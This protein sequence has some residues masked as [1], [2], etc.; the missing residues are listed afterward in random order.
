MEKQLQDQLA[1]SGNEDDKEN[2]LK[3]VMNLSRI[4]RALAEF[5][6]KYGF[7]ASMSDEN[8][9]IKVLEARVADQASKIADTR[10]KIQNMETV[11]SSAHTWSNYSSI[12]ALFGADERDH[13][14]L[15]GEPIAWRDRN[16]WACVCGSRRA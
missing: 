9:A 3:V 10:Q 13:V 15:D 14:L 4:Q 5:K 12:K 11:S 2:K 8:E 16:S 7:D 6:E 1:Q